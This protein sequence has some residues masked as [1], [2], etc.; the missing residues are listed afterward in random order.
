MRLDLSDPMDMEQIADTARR[1]LS[2]PELRPGL[3]MLSDHSE[4]EFTAT[5]EIAK[6]VP[7]LLAQLAE[8]L[9]PFRFAAVVPSDASYG[10]ARMTGVLA[11]GSPA[12]FRAFRSLE[13]A[14]AWLKTT[15]VRSGMEP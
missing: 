11:E 5:T 8:R 14:E 9:G 2:D 3:N 1:L 15:G 7:R 6:L 12:E 13:E 4:L 10:M